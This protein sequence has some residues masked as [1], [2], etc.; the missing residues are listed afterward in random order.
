MTGTNNKHK[1][2]KNS[3]S[4]SQNKS[5]I[6]V[7]GQAKVQKSA[8]AEAELQSIG[9]ISFVTGLITIIP[10]LIIIIIG[11]IMRASSSYDTRLRASYSIPIVFIEYIALF[12][13]PLGAI[14][15]VVTIIRILHLRCTTGK[16]PFNKNL[17]LAITGIILYFMP[18]VMFMT[19]NY[20]MFYIPLV[21]IILIIRLANKHRG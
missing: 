4:R 19:I 1:T 17:L 21:L 5:A 10:A 3:N 14:M 7:K 20:S 9:M 2:S 13:L 11:Y 16:L 8:E 6:K 12:V 18:I 15:T